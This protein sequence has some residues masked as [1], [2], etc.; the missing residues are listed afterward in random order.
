MVTQGAL[1]FFFS[2][3]QNE[4]GLALDDSKRY[5][6]ETRL[7]PVAIQ[8][9]FSSID[10][11]VRH[12]RENSSPLLR[13]KVVDAMT[14]NET[15][16]F[17]DVTP[18]EMMRSAIL[19]DL[20]KTNERNRRIRIWSAGCATGQEPYSIAM[21]L[22]D[23]APSL[24]NWNASILATDIAEKVLQRAQAGVYSQYEVQR[25]LPVT[26][27]TRYFNQDGIQW[28]IKPEVK[29][30]VEFRKINFL[31]DFSSLD[32]FDVIFCRN[33]L[34]YFDV[35]TKK[36]VLEQAAKVLAPGGFLF[37]GGA[38]TLLGITGDFARFETGR[39]SYYRKDGSAK[40]P[41]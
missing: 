9:G 5:L 12:M 26:Y 18:F 37:L 6:I 28:G 39:A 7:E 4:S 17:R 10:D 19:P 23:L 2:L 11:L 32:S 20:L 40:K 41:K 33:V 15:S 27:L 38:E 35:D 31:S 25:G 16:F 14:T 36:K 1:H 24:Q 8:E 22:C 3:L 13:Q 30:L 29:R 34:I 21:L